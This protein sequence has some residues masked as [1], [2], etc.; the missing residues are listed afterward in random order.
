MVIPRNHPSFLNLKNKKNH[1]PISGCVFIKQALKMEEPPYSQQTKFGAIINSAAPSTTITTATNST[2]LSTVQPP[3]SRRRCKG[4]K[5]KGSHINNNN[6]LS[7][8]RSSSNLK[9][10]VELLG[11][12]DC[13]WRRRMFNIVYVG[14]VERGSGVY[15]L[16]RSSVI[17]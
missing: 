3:S 14:D 7:P 2:P 8:P 10:V 15:C 6:T 11:C 12:S 4:V 16:E 9:Y 5:R 1:L 13:E 17:V